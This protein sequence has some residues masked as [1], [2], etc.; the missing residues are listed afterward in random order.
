LSG[1]ASSAL[2]TAAGSKDKP[3][4]NGAN[5]GGQTGLLLGFL[6]IEVKETGVAGAISA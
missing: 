6:Y 4:G 1:G 3:T 5:G 2:L